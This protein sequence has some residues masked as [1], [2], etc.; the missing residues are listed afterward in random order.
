MQIGPQDATVDPL[1]RMQH[2]VVVFQ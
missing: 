2:M 1:H